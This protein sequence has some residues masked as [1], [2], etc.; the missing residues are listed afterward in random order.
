[1]YFFSPRGNTI[2][3]ISYIF[4]LFPSFL[5]VP[6][7]TNLIYITLY[8]I[9]DNI[10]AHIYFYRTFPEIVSHVTIDYTMETCIFCEGILYVSTVPDADTPKLPSFH[11]IMCWTMSCI[12][13]KVISPFGWAFS[14]CHLPYNVI[15]FYV[16]FAATLNASCIL[17]LRKWSELHKTCWAYRM[18]SF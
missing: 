10:H 13:G 2:G 17:L 6:I 9:Y 1:M 14:L 11:N 7:S 15:V 16:F 18:L 5:S 12:A 4:F 3:Y 8:Y